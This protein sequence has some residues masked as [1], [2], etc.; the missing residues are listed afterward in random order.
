MNQYNTHSNL[1]MRNQDTQM[2]VEL[3]SNPYESIANYVM[4]IPTDSPQEEK[5]GGPESAERGEG[6]EARTQNLQVER[7]LRRADSGEAKG[8]MAVSG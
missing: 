5:R 3:I 8:D 1:K 7:L 2:E 4:D 6:H